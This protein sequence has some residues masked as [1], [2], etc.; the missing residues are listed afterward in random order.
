ML[1][2]ISAQMFPSCGSLSQ[3]PYSRLQPL[4]VNNLVSFILLSS[5]PLWDTAISNIPFNSLIHYMDCLLPAFHHWN[6]SPMKTRIFVS[7]THVPQTPREDLA[8]NLCTKMCWKLN[9]WWIRK[10][11]RIQNSWMAEITGYKTQRKTN[12]CPTLAINQALRCF[13]PFTT[14]SMTSLHF[15]L[16]IIKH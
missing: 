6:S 16:K 7:F 12:L 9:E 3:K 11:A 4:P 2:W 8:C 1:P 5:F 14:F 10:R 13:P 15:P